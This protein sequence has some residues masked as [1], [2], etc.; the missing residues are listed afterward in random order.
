MTAVRVACHQLAPVVGD[1]EGNRRRALRAVERAAAAGAHLVVLP[2]LVSSGYV[3]RD[4]AEAAS[5]A[6]PADGPT[7]AGWREAPAGADPA[8]APLGIENRLG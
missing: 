5:L 4:A 2:E 7:L 8:P 1:L 3:F 6:E